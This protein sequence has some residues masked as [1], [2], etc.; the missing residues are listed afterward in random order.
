MGTVCEAVDANRNTDAP[1]VQEGLVRP[2]DTRIYHAS[3]D[4]VCVN[5]A[6]WIGKRCYEAIRGKA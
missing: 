4:A 6:N 2:P 5:V 3:G 1:G